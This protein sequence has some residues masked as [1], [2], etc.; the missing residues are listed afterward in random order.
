MVYPDSRL[1]GFNHLVFLP[2]LAH[3][4]YVAAALLI[5]SLFIPALNLPFARLNEKSAAML[6][7]KPHTL[8]WLF[9][10][11]TAVAIFWIFKRPTHFLGDGYTIINNIAAEGAVVYKW[12]EI[13]AIRVI[14][15]VARVL[16]LDS[17][18]G[19]EQAFAFVS[20]LSGGVAIY[21]MHAIAREIFEHPSD[22]LLLFCLMV[23]SGW[24]L[25][26]FGYAENY[27]VLWPFLLG[28]ILTA[29]RYINGHGHW[30]WPVVIATAAVTIHLQAAVFAVSLPVM[31][32]SRGPLQRTY[33]R[34]RGIISGSAIALAVAGIAFFVWKYFTSV[35]F[36]IHFL[37]LLHGRPIAPDYALISLPHF[38]DIFNLLNLLIP[39]W[40]LLLLPGLVLF[41]VREF[42]WIDKFLIAFSIGGL[43]FL[44]LIDPRLGMGRDWDLF[45]ACLLGPSIFLSCRFI[46]STG[47]WQNLKPLLPLIAALCV[48]P[49]F[50]TNLSKEPSINYVKFLL[51]L[52]ESISKPG[53]VTLQN[54]YRDNGEEDKA[55]EIAD[56]TFVRYPRG[57]SI[58]FANQL[59]AEGK[60]KAALHIADSLYMDDPWSREVI[61]L[62]GAIHLRRGNI[63]KGFEYLR[64][65]LA[66]SPYDYRSI[67]NMAWGFQ[68]IGRNDSAIVYLLRAH[69]LAP[70]E[71]MPING[72]ALAYCN[73][74]DYP[75][76][77]E[78]CTRLIEIDPDNPD[79]YF[80][81]GKSAYLA[82]RRK[83][84]LHLLSKYLMMEPGTEQANEA[85]TLLQRLR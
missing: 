9:I 85:E 11:G 21:L 36:A 58:I 2:S 51:K 38:L 78:Y 31:I 66:L 40:P 74:R 14:D 54:W 41:R 60:H 35:G 67:T 33:K 55:K 72:L 82:N 7:H 1:W 39:T 27:P 83:E 71:I 43:A 64:A 4:T 50:I 70:R 77:F 68:A 19:A 6:F 15:M 73:K 62:L 75:T 59:S 76:A 26:F 42:D 30:I 56:Y 37:P 12:T 24:T 23:F 22:R 81:G 47:S 10:S 3:Y 69:R 20:I 84:A 34:Y 16:S 52:D 44:F 65:G 8:A 29:I 45:A 49:F 48:I 13:G 57:R 5:M 17:I 53:W 25:L 79:W 28:Y 32:I 63:Q 46:Q 18:K 80:I 61:N